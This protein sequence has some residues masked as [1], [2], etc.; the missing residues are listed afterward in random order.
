M[1]GVIDARL[2][3]CSHCEAKLVT[4]ARDRSSAIIRR[5]C[6]S[7]TA[8][9]WSLPAIA[10]SSSS[11]SGILLHRKKD[12][13]D[14]SSM[15]LT[16]YGVRGG[17]PAGSGSRRKRKC[18]LTRTADSA[19]S[20]PASKPSS[21][22]LFSKRAIG[23]SRSALVTGRRYARFINVVRIR[24]A[25]RSSRPRAV[26]RRPENP[27]PAGRVSGRRRAI[28]ADDRDRVDGRLD[29]RM[30]VRI[31]A[32]LVGPARGLDEQRRFLQ[33]RHAEGVRPRL[34]R[35]P[36]R[37]VLIGGG[38]LGRR[39]AEDVSSNTWTRALS[40]SSSRSWISVRPST[41]SSRSRVR[42]I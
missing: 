32:C 21:A 11:S 30:P 17:T 25:S 29:P 31:E 5:T 18:G 15:S 34:H 7:S 9:S 22:R 10:S 28:G 4:S 13:R 41:C 37:E 2:R 40:M 8:G 20:I 26:G 6:R 39:A 3:R 24:V 23:R 14:A 33:E 42:R 12:S 1:S 27:A 35:H 38:V 36:D 19:I 16:R